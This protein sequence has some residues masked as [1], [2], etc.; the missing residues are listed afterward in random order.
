MVTAGAT[1][2]GCFSGLRGGEGGGVQTMSVA[3]HPRAYAE[4]VRSDR[5]IA[6]SPVERAR[7]IAPLIAA[8]A[9]VIE[10]RRSLPTDVVDALHGEG[11][12]RTLL[13]RSASGEE[14]EPAEYVQMMMV[15]AAAD[16]STA[17]CVGQASGCSMAAAY[18]EPEAVRAIWGDDPRAVL[19][20]GAGA[21]AVAKA[22]DGGYRVSGGWGFASGNRHATWLGG[23]CRVEER[24]GTLR[25]WPDGT[26][27][28][29]TMLFP[30]GQAKIDG[31]WEVMGLRGTGSDSYSVADLFVPDEFTVC[32]D[33]APFRREAGPL[34][35][36]S[37]TNLYG[38]GF[39]AVALGIAR[40]CLDALVELASVK[41]PAGMSRG[42]RESPVV[43]TD[44]ALGEAKLQSA[45]LLLIDT[46]RSA[47]T[48]VACGAG[49]S[50]DMRMR[51][52]MAATFATHQAKE[53]VDMAYHD[54]GASAIFE[55]HPFERRFRD[56]HSVSQQVQARY[57]HFETIGA[58]LLGLPTSLRHI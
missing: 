11:L 31:H 55:S 45:T 6:G 43:Q 19:A 14:I 35:K 27:V 7:R 21:S 51:I 29:R 22:V 57:S 24:D 20:W 33:A 41:K 25:C 39:G 48:E 16:A 18:M 8:H 36:F 30:R 17:W 1:N 12:F 26:P 50:L 49:M 3:I 42:L 34:Y 9:D 58:H 28:E 52:R 5:R 38:S 54:A 13:P 53:V 10:R 2:S 15:L 47:W 40:A 4:R 44:L 56:I 23:H 46:L 32:R 37:T